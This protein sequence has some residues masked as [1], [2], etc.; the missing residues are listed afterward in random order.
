MS[1]PHTGDNKAQT[2]YRDGG[3]VKGSY[4]LTEPDGTVRVVD[5]SADPHTGFNAVVKR[6][7]TAGHPGHIVAAA[8]V[9]APV[10]IVKPL[11][12]LPLAPAH[13]FINVAGPLA[14]DYGYSAYPAG[15]WKH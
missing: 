12:P 1:D 3:V 6:L 13:S 10:A 4:S 5:Y 11:A 15:L 14:V 9:M 7:G 2:E 8:P